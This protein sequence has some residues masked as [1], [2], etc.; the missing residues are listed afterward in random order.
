MKG[1]L[2]KGEGGWFV[3]YVA[4]SKHDVG[5]IIKELPLHPDNIKEIKEIKELSESFDNLEAR[6]FANRGVDFTIVEE[7][8][9]YDGK[10]FGK[11]CGCKEGFVQ[12]AKI[13]IS[14]KF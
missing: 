8:F 9:N 13:K 2:E 4:L 12:Y 1:F 5:T 7:C 14:D 10:H 6:I 11:D 3:C